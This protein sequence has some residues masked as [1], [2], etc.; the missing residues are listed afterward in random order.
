MLYNIIIYFTGEEK[1]N[2]RV[3]QVWKL[4]KTE[5]DGDAVK[6]LYVYRNDDGVDI[7]VR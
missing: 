3:V 2:E 6:V 7:P 4:E 1:Y 5:D